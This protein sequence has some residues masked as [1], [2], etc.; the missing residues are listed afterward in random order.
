MYGSKAMKMKVN[1][2]YMIFVTMRVFASEGMVN[3]P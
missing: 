1:D 2:L 3:S